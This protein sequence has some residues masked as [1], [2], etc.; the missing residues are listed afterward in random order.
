MSKYLTESVNAL[1]I[2]ITP[3]EIVKLIEGESIKTNYDRTRR[4][5]TVL[6]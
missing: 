4:K 1:N 3:S 2:Y 5:Q 6:S